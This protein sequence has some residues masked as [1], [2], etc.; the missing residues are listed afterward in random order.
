ML[1]AADR[2]DDKAS[3]FGLGADDYLTT[4]RGAG[5]RIGAAPGTGHGGG[6]GG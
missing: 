2:L 1:T 5:Y 4:V 6:D 3:G